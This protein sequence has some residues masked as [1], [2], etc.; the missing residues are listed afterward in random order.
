MKKTRSKKSRDTVPLNHRGREC[1]RFFLNSYPSLLPRIESTTELISHKESIPWNRCLG[2][3]NRFPDVIDFSQ[4]ID[5]AIFLLLF[6]FRWR[7][8][9]TWPTGSCLTQWSVLHLSK[10]PSSPPPSQTGET[11]FTVELITNF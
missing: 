4:G 11:P 2:T 7:C 6:L 5:S 8:D 9:P 10:G 3:C 1:T